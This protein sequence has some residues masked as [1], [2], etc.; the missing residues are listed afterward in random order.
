MEKREYLA[1]KNY[2]EEVIDYELHKGHQ[3][4]PMFGN[5]VG[6]PTMFG[7]S[8]NFAPQA[9]A[10]PV[11]IFPLAEQS[12]DPSQASKGSLHVD[13]NVQALRA[14][15]G[16]VFDDLLKYVDLSVPATGLAK[17]ETK[18]T[19]N[20]LRSEQ[21]PRW[22]QNTVDSVG[23][24][25]V[26]SSM[27]NE[28][29]DLT[30]ETSASNSRKSSV[31]LSGSHGSLPELLRSYQQQ[32]QQ[33]QAAAMAQASTSTAAT[34][35]SLQTNQQGSS[36]SQAG[37][38]AHLQQQAFN[39]AFNNPFN[40]PFAPFGGFH[41]FPNIGHQAGFSAGMN[42]TLGHFGGAYHMPS[43]FQ[44]NMV[45]DPT[46][47]VGPSGSSSIPPASSS[48]VATSAAGNSALAASSGSQTAAPVTHP[49]TAPSQLSA[50]SA[51]QQSGPS[52]TG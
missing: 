18:K 47:L 41:A 19:L 38:Q 34:S 26:G 44:P 36:L 37:Q 31:D 49:A 23:S 22:D 30:R 14:K 45:P 4:H 42:P 24:S 5:P 9:P 40:F 10:S 3:P 17:G 13:S 43:G 46:R 1:G 21:E 25:G 51:P 48:G 27:G 33:L 32:Q 16:R 8:P 2:D 35:S 11:P 20:E 6:S 39:A 12:F 52:N 15:G 7:V 29:L 28:L 50:S